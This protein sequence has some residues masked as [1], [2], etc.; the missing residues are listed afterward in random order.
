MIKVNEDNRQLRNQLDKKEG[1]QSAFQSNNRAYAERLDQLDKEAQIKDADIVKLT[2]KVQELE[3]NN[4]QLRN[5]SNL[6]KG[7]CTNL[8]RD[9][10]LHTSAVNKLST[11][12][13]SMGDQINLYKNRI[14]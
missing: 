4:D 1:F 11:D 6:Y 2:Q 10:E 7:R 13:G 12:Q 8:Q 9:I 14:Q 3:I 5:E